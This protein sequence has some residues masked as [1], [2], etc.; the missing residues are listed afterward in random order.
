MREGEDRPPGDPPGARSSIAK[1]PQPGLSRP[2]RQRG[3]E[4]ARRRWSGW[5]GRWSGSRGGG[6]AAGPRPP[7][8]SGLLEELSAPS[9]STSESVRSDQR[10]QD[11]GMGGTAQ[12]RLARKKLWR[13]VTTLVYYAIR[14]ESLL[15]SSRIVTFSSSLSFHASDSVKP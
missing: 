7:R 10:K 12:H 11:G 15:I 13:L 3:P 1:P 9:P 14:L 4:S 5:R 2:C 6:I 8:W